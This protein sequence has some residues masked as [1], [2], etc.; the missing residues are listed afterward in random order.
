MTYARLLVIEYVIGK[1]AVQHA[2]RMWLWFRSL[3][4]YYLKNRKSIDY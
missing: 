3:I 4:L 2:V 1:S